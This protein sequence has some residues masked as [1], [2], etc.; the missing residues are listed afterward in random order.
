[1]KKFFSDSIINVTKISTGTVAGQIVSIATLPFITRLYGAEIIGLWTL[2]NSYSNIVQN[3]CDLGLSNSLMM[4]PEDTI[5][6]RYSIIVKISL[7]LSIVSAIFISFYYIFLH[8]SLI[9]ILTIFIFVAIYS[10]TLRQISICSMVLNR[11]K[12][13]DV[14]MKNSFIRFSSVAIVSIVLGVLGFTS[15][16]YFIGNILGQ[17]FTI[18]HMKKCLP[19]FYMHN[20]LSEYI[21]T[22][23]E[24]KNYVKYQMPA[25]LTVNL[26][27]ELPNLLIS[28]LFGNAMLGYFSISQ[29]LL[30]IP[31]TFLGQALG[32]VFFQKISEMKLKGMNIGKFVNKSINQGMI[33]AIVPMSLLAAFGDALI[34]F[35]FGDEYSVGGIICRI[36][37]YRALFN[38][39]SSATQGL[40]IVLGKQQ[41]VLYTCLVQTIFASLSV[42]IGF[43][44]FNN[45]YVTS[46]LLAVSFIIIQMIYFYKM[47]RFMDLNG[48]SY[49]KNMLIIITLLFLISMSLR[50]ITLFILH[51]FDNSLFEYLLTLFE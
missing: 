16:G 39:I 41:Y 24:N 35:F 1:M 2:I 12:E 14:L 7:F 48:N 44:F 28:A 42:I 40:D 22:I 50:Y 26:R 19:T 9:Y 23:Y 3:V 31:V 34:V 37:V 30:T 27:T 43:Y 25:S 51:T 45:I 10:F 18:I 38:F 6:E 33:I 13:Y 11:N 20:D 46:I 5:A 29:K 32:K 49:L 8:T 36:I 47:Y 17:M 21:N 4:C 15:Y